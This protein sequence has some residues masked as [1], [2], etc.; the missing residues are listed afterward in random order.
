MSGQS[1]IF[2]PHILDQSVW[3]REAICKLTNALR[4]VNGQGDACPGLTIDQYHQHFVIQLFHK[5]WEC[6]LEKIVA[7]LQNKFKPQYIIAKWRVS[8]NGRS[9]D[10]PQVKVLF[11]QTGSKTVVIENGLKFQVDVNDAVNVGLFLDMRDNRQRVAGLVK[12]KSVLNTFAYTCSFGVYGKTAGAQ[13]V[14]NIDISKKVLEKGKANYQLNNLEIRPQEFLVR[15][16]EDYLMW[17][18]K[19]EKKF[20]C[21]ILDPPSFSRHDGHVFSIQ[22]KLPRLIEMA[23]Q[24]LNPRGQL[25]IATNCSSITTRQLKEYV[26]TKVQR[27]KFRVKQIESY[28]QAGDFTESGKMKESCLAAI[29]VSLS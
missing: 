11:Q 19:K 28:H 21:I 12:G 16:T 2:N 26:L 13:E 22:K 9:L 25:F 14:V 24:S 27:L 1:I 4:L 15:D 5:K 18:L 7:Y 17:C 6:F 23:I 20:D 8:E 3:K 10:V 29:L